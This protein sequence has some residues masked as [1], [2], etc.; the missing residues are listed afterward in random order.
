MN[1]NT[2]PA[3]TQVLANGSRE[4]TAEKRPCYVSVQLA[5]EIA[6]V[7]HRA[8]YDTFNR[9]EPGTSDVQVSQIWQFDAGA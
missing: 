2:T 1:H 5:G 4:P 8:L 9:G 7:S 6:L 3:S